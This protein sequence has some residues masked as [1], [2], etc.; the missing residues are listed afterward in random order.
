[1]IPLLFDFLRSIIVWLQAKRM[2]CSFQSLGR[3]KDIAVNLILRIKIMAVAGSTDNLSVFFSGLNDI[4]NNLL[5]FIHR[6]NFAFMDLIDIVLRRLYLNEVIEL[7][8]LSQVF[9]GFIPSCFPDFT[10]QTSRSDNQVL[11]VFGKVTLRSIRGL[12]FS[13]IDCR[14]L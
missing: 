3:D 9:F 14:R 2:S 10:I 5:N 11:A 8:L 6:S 7:H 4:L 13:N 1:M 12:V